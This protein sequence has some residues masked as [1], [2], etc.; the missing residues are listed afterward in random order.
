MIIRKKPNYINIEIIDCFDNEFFNVDF[1]QNYNE[2]LL[3]LK[4]LN[5]DI[6]ELLNV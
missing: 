4:Q 2:Y 5:L 1:K 3:F 6:K